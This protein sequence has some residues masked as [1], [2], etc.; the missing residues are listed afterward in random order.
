LS[1]FMFSDYQDSEHDSLFHAWCQRGHPEGSRSN[2]GA[3]SASVVPQSLV[4][5]ARMLARAYVLRLAWTLCS[6]ASGKLRSR[7]AAVAVSQGGTCATHCTG[8]LLAMQPLPALPRAQHFC[9]CAASG[10]D[11]TPHTSIL[12]QSVSIL[13]CTVST[14]MGR[15][16]IGV[17]VFDSTVVVPR[18]KE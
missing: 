17:N 2:A 8:E 11:A 1:F 12:P 9:G 13:L 4:L 14:L 7:P 5:R 3:F 10:E 18:G 16:L 15:F 6:C